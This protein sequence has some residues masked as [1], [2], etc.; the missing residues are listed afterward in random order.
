MAANCSSNALPALSESGRPLLDIARLVEQP[1]H[2]QNPTQIAIPKPK[3]VFMKACKLV[4]L[5]WLF[6]TLSACNLFT[7]CS[8]CNKGSLEVSINVPSGVTITPAVVVTGPD[9]STT[10]SQSTTL[11]SLSN[12][13]Y[14]IA[15]SDAR[16]SGLVV[17]RVFAPQVSASSVTVK[18]NTTSKVQIDFALR[19]GSGKLWLPVCPDQ[20]DPA[21]KDQV[22]AFDPNQLEKSGTPTTSIMLEL[23]KGA[24]AKAAVIDP[25]GNLLVTLFAKNQ[26]VSFNPTQQLVS[27]APIPLQV[28]LPYNPPLNGPLDAALNNK[29]FFVSNLSGQLTAKGIVGGPRVDPD[30]F[31]PDPAVVMPVGVAFFGESLWVTSS[32]NTVVEYTTPQLKPGQLLPPPAITLS[33]LAATPTLNQPMGIAFDSSDNMWISNKGGNTIVKFTPA[34]YAQNGSPDP[35]VTLGGDTTTLSKPSGLAFDN[36]GNLWVWNGG[37]RTLVKFLANDLAKSG[38][39]NPNVILNLPGTAI[40]SGVVEDQWFAFNP[41]SAN[42]PVSK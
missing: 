2:H 9:S 26:A 34:Q 41:P 16:E 39:P 28:F 5:L 12:G 1:L 8:V 3:G 35:D 36:A 38:N 31:T 40:P 18:A 32:T 20:V 42:L 17:D 14:T 25:T 6:L 33:S 13:T 10:L 21:S 4:V 27:G 7:T 11:S 37:N 30:I 23:E 15:A 19:P 24:C 29:R 22:L